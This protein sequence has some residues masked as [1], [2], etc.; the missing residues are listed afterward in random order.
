MCL[1]WSAGYTRRPL[2][3]DE[4]LM[5]IENKAEYVAEPALCNTLTPLVGVDVFVEAL[6]GFQDFLE[7]VAHHGMT[8]VL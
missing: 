5:Q 3:L 4:H 1:N 8:N 2:K 6:G 7:V